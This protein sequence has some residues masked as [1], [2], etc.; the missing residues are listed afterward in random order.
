L[1]TAGIL[2]LIALAVVVGVLRELSLGRSAGTLSDDTIVATQQSAT[3]AP[4]ASAVAQAGTMPAVAV[5]ELPDEALKTIMMINAGGPFPFAQDG[6]VFQNRE[7]LLPEQ[8]PGYY[9]EYTVLT[10]DSTDRGPRRIVAGSNGEFYYT[11]D[12]YASFVRV[13]L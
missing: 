11:D 10:P 3:I 8:P 12:H 5:S 1:I 13:S 4:V 7:R 2:L 9:H 6:T